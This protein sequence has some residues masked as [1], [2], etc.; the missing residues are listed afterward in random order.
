MSEQ[1]RTLYLDF[2]KESI[3][4]GTCGCPYRLFQSSERRTSMRL[5]PS[6]TDIDTRK[7]EISMEDWESGC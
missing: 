5:R 6:S 3:H 4:P 1:D 2:G 7:E